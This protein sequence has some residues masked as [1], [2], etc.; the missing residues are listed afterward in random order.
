MDRVFL[1]TLELLTQSLP[2][3]SLV[4]VGGPSGTRPGGGHPCPSPYFLTSKLARGESLGPSR[5]VPER[6]HSVHV[7]V[8]VPGI[9]GGSKS[10]TDISVSSFSFPALWLV[11]SPV[12]HCLG[13]PQVATEAK[14]L[15]VS[16]FNKCSGRKAFCGR[17]T[18]G[19]VNNDSS[20]NWIF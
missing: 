12:T 5:A 9:L 16:V 19:P 6:A 4:S 11:C 15:P 1:E 2:R 8:Y 18:P 13:L 3:G 17:R 10:P 14:H 20:A 7:A